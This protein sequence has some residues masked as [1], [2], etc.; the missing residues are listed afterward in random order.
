MKSFTEYYYSNQ[1][2]EDEIGGACGT[3]RGMK[4]AWNFVE[5]GVNVRT[6]LKWILDK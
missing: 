5:L 6:I 4:N 3:H 1:L 2:K